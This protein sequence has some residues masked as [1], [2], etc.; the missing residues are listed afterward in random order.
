MSEGQF[1]GYELL[2]SVFWPDGKAIPS[3][4][5]SVYISVNLVFMVNGVFG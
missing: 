1:L 5:M 2:L 3:V 4:R